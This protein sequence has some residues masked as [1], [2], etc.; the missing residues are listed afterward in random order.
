VLVLR[1][2]TERREAIDAGCAL[3]VGADPGVILREASA[4]LARPDLRNRMTAADNPFGD[5]HAA[6]R[7][8]DAIAWL[9]GQG[10]RPM[11]F[12]GRRAAGVPGQHA[13]PAKSCSGD[14]SRAASPSS[15]NG[16][17]ET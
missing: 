3:L 15:P 5:G 10:D 14:R 13:S 12:G 16:D 6:Q 1:D 9:L 7:T 2:V 4:L 17:G 11:P 8:V